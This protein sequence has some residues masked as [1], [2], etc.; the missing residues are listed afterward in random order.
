MI[1]RLAHTYV[2]SPITNYVFKNY[3][4][5]FYDRRLKKYLEPIY[6][7][8]K[9]QPLKKKVSKILNAIGTRYRDSKRFLAERKYIKKQLKE[10]DRAQKDLIKNQGRNVA[11]SM[12]GGGPPTTLHPTIL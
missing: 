5:P 9:I 6:N 8:R 7:H 1:Y 10:F 2:I 12:K 3:L 4:K 11:K